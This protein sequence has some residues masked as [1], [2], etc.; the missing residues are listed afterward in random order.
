M[1]A[2][3]YGAF[4]NNELKPFLQ[5]SDTIDPSM[6]ID[7]KLFVFS[8]TDDSKWGL[9]VDLIYFGD[10]TITEEYETR[11]AY[12]DSGNTTIQV[13]SD[14]FAKILNEIKEAFSQDNENG[15]IKIKL[16]KQPNKLVKAIEV[17][18]GCES[19]YFLLPTFEFT[20][21]SSVTIKIEPLNYL[22]QK[23]SEFGNLYCMI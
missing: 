18:Q 13:P 1:V 19:I 4:Q 11:T 10:R 5:I 9:S 20:I 14:H 2:F 22:E 7:E 21:E 3:N 16:I 23:E 6:T 15:L 17:N 8:S 12:I